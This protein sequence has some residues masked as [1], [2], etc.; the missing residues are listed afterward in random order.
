[1]DNSCV[2]LT[3]IS[4]ELDI[5]RDVIIIIVCSDGQERAVKEVVSTPVVKPSLYNF[6][7]PYITMMVEMQILLNKTGGFIIIQ[8][9]LF[10][11]ISRKA[12][13]D[14]QMPTGMLRNSHEM[15][16][17]AIFLVWLCR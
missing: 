4:L 16:C 14:V 1:M 2:V 7:F 12:V 13:L 11:S 8:T 15:S 9:G 17:A 10:V 3:P 6:C 5:L